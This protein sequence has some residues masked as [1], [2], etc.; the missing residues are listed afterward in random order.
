MHHMTCPH[1]CCS[2][3]VARQAGCGV[4]SL[5]LLLAQQDAGIHI[6]QEVQAIWPK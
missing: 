3:V 4:A 6:G 1:E 5:W 2:K